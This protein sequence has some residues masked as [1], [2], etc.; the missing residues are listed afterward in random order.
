MIDHEENQ[1]ILAS[2][3]ASLDVTAGPINL[4]DVPEE[5]ERSTALRLLTVS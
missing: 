3:D 2:R 5:E 4:S 1:E